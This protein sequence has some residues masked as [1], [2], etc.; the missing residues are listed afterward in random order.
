MFEIYLHALK[1][2][3]I[4][5]F[6]NF[7]HIHCTSKRLKKSTHPIAY[8]IWYKLNSTQLLGN[9]AF[10]QSDDYCWLYLYGG[11][12]FSSLQGAFQQFRKNIKI[13]RL[14]F[15]DTSKKTPCIILHFSCHLFTY[16]GLLFFEGFF[17]LCQICKNWIQ[18]NK[19]HF[20]LCL[21]GQNLLGFLTNKNVSSFEI[22]YQTSKNE[23]II[24][25]KRLVVSRERKASC[26][27][28]LTTTL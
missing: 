22:H 9:Y 26:S 21:Y 6:Y 3:E 14:L 2:I 13:L 4:Y 27:V 11:L 19:I 18:P 23:W 25:V 24:N 7:E 28:S 20:I 16:K 15:Y 1:N 12:C 5:E 17:G 8:P 10:W